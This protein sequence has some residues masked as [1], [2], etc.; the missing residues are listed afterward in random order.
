[1]P[2]EC[3]PTAAVAATRYQYQGV[4]LTPLKQTPSSEAD[5]PLQRQTPIWRQIPSMDK[6]TLPKHNLP[7]VVVNKKFPPKWEI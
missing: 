1:M 5:R 2:V 7:L 6:Q 3:I 4:R